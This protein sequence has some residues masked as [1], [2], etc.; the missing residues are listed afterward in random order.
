[1]KIAIIIGLF[2]PK[3]LAG[4]EIATSNLAKQLAKRGHEIHVITSHDEGLPNF[5]K[6]NGF[7]IHRFVWP[8]IRIIGVIPFWLLVF[9]KI[10]TIKPDIVHAQ[11]LTIG[12]PAYLSRKILK[13]PYIVWGRGSDIYRPSR[14]VRITIPTILQNA[15][16]IIALTENMRIEL[17]KFYDKEIYV[18]PNG[19]DLDKYSDVVINFEKEP[20]EKNILF[21]GS[22]YPVKG[23]Q[24][25]IMAMKTVHDRMPMIRLI[26][27]GDGEE[28]ERLAALSIKLGIQ[29]YV[30]F[31]GKVPHEKVLTFMQNADVFVLPSL[32]EGLPNVLLE[33]MACGLPIVATN[34]GGI[35]DIITNGV[36]GFL[37]GVKDTEDIA[38]KIL[39]LLQDDLARK[40]ISDNN[41][42]IVKKYTWNNVIVE[43]E[44]IYE[45]A[46][47]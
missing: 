26:L 19:I 44:K 30:Q 37:V 8:K 4:T 24:Y 35:P 29:E 3:W 31:V 7:Y 6:E 14:R 45:L 22:M 20:G 25:L 11:D 21:V 33:A 5:N 17:K 13:I 43:L 28:S 15:D 34:V 10:C 36:N 9:L 38:N 1:M 12:T 23:V 42:Q 2:P 47:K 27:V 32:S 41:K 39:I 18:I 40:K 16:A 46:I